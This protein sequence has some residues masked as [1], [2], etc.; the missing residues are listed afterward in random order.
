MGDWLVLLDVFGPFV[1]FVPF[2][3]LQFGTVKKT[4]IQHAEYMY[5]TNNNSYCRGQL[6]ALCHTTYK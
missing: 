2:C 6:C 4:V 1:P 3:A 5:D